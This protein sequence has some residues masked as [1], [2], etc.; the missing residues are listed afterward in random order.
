M[1]SLAT[2][3]VKGEDHLGNSNI[4]ITQ[5]NR[6]RHS[7]GGISLRSVAETNFGSSQLITK[8]LEG[9]NQR[10]NN[11]LGNVKEQM[12]MHGKLIPP[13]QKSSGNISQLSLIAKKHYLPF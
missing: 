6:E 8:R 11:F 5:S 3:G 4:T 10:V 12:K 7:I 13:P 1:T 9:S 2:E